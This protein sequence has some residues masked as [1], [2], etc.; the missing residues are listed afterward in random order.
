MIIF[1]RTISNE[2]I[3][4]AEMLCN[5]AIRSREPVYV[6]IYGKEDKELGEVCCMPTE[7]KT[8]KNVRS[9]QIS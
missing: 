8:R 9:L 3:E 4:E 7:E 5:A 6:K 1:V 2:V